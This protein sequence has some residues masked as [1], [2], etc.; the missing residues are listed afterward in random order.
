[1]KTKAFNALIVAALMAM[2]TVATAQDSTKTK[3]NTI[4][5][6][7]QQKVPKK[8]KQ[9]DTSGDGTISMQEAKEAN[10]QKLYKNFKDAD[11]SG[12][13]TVD[14]K[15]FIAYQKTMKKE[16]AMRGKDMDPVT[17]KDSSDY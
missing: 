14:V 15:E 4:K 2:G 6:R 13:G 1:M 16:G 10:D 8:M 5:S 12:D 7:M 3:G 11:T 17:K 9:M